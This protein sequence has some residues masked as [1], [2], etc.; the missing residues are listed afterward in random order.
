VLE[1]YIEV[2]DD[3]F[4]KTSTLSWYFGLSWA[5]VASLT[6]KPTTKTKARHAKKK[7]AAKKTTRARK[8]SGSRSKKKVPPKTKAAGKKAR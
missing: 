6:P 3:L 4:K 5:Y 8:K 1:E 2:T 7:V